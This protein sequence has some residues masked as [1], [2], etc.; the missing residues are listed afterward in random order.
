M[1]QGRPQVLEEAS[2]LGLLTERLG[3]SGEGVGDLGPGG[4]RGGDL[5]EEGQPS[6]LLLFPV[7]EVLC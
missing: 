4:C 6:D 1:A 7:R 3:D 2:A 5:E